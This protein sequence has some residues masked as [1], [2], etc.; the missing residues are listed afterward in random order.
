MRR[1]ARE[2]C[3]LTVPSGSTVPG[4]TVQVCFVPQGFCTK[5][6]ESPIVNNAPSTGE[7]VPDLP[8][9]PL[10]PPFKGSPFHI[11]VTIPPYSS[12]DPRSEPWPPHRRPYST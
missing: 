2:A 11:P 1:T 7:D 8:C 9:V 12:D 5:E 3:G 10:C 4:S 6:D